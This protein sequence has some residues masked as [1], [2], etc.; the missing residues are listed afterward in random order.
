MSSKI[1]KIRLCGLS[2]L[3]LLL[4]ACSSSID[5]DTDN[6]YIRIYFYYPDSTLHYII[7]DDATVQGAIYYVPYELSFLANADKLGYTSAG[8]FNFSGGTPFHIGVSFTGKGTGVYYWNDDSLES[9]LVFQETDSA[10]DQSY[11]FYSGKTEV[12]KYG[13]VGER[14][15][16]SFSGN[17]I[18]KSTS[19]TLEI[20]GDFSLIRRND[21]T[22][23]TP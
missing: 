9:M 6:Q 13:K 14:V 16:G 18:L 10:F 21:F 4:I 7:E 1:F 15:K 23:E 5:P 2:I 19:D 3:Y 20:F 11:L 8:L 22:F 12:T 17:A